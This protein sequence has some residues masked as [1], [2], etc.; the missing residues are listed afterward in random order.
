M[1]GYTHYNKQRTNHGS[2]TA[3]EGMGIL[4]KCS[5]K[6][7]YMEKRNTTKSG[8]NGSKHIQVHTLQPENT[9]RTDKTII[10]LNSWLLLR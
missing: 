3:L 8:I 4:S 1:M 5:D 9:K 10:K 2:Y 6:M 7:R